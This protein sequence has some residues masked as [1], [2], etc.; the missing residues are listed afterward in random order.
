MPKNLPTMQETRGLMPGLGR[1][2]GERN[3][4]SLQY[5]CLE[6]SI[7]REAWCATV[8]GVTELDMIERLTFSHF[9]LTTLWS[10]WNG[11]QRIRMKKYPVKKNPF[12]KEDHSLPPVS[13]SPI[14]QEH[15]NPSLFSSQCEEH[16]INISHPACSW[17]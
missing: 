16:D 6:N 9:N 1:L 14:S 11:L 17:G 12:K 5:S 7:D 13:Q 8:H 10:L 4:Y 2:F 15:G 3:S